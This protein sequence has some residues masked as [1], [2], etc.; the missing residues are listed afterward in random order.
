LQDLQA[1]SLR[2]GRL[3]EASEA[4]QRQQTSEFGIYAPYKYEE[5]RDLPDDI[6]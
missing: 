1:S 6:S 4:P 2:R 3:K 5:R